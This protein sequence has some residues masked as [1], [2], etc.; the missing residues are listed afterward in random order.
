MGRAILSVRCSP[1][2]HHRIHPHVAI[3]SM[4]RITTRKITKQTEKQKHV[5][6]ADTLIAKMTLR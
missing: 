1:E 6:R 5:T 2:W 4:V 3:D